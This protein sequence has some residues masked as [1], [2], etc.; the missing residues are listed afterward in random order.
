[1]DSRSQATKSLQD[2]VRTVMDRCGPTPPGPDNAL[3]ARLTKRSLSTE[4]GTGR[5]ATTIW[6]PL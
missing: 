5:R 1:M 6:D 2:W 4:P 3:T